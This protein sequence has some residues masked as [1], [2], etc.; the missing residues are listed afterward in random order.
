MFV[1]AY[2]KIETFTNEIKDC[3]RRVTATGLGVVTGNDV[4]A[5]AKYYRYTA[6]HIEFHVP[7][8]HTLN[9][10]QADLEM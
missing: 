3:V 4:Y 1:P 8:E 7:A 10:T 5:L 9:G 6:T 2:T